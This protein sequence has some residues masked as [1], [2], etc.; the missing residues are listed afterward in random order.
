MNKINILYLFSKPRYFYIPMMIWFINTMAYF[1]YLFGTEPW[2]DYKV[3]ALVLLGILF[4]LIWDFFKT[5]DLQENHKQSL[6]G[7]Q[8]T[9]HTIHS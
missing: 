8:S 3:V 6:L 9:N 7:S 4:Y 1:P 5:A 2:F